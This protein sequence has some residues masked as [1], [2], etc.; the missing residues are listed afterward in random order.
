MRKFLYDVWRLLRFIALRFKQ[1]RCGQAAASLTFTTLL[2][3]VPMITIALTIFGAFPVFQDFSTEI[4]NYLLSN[5]MP[6]KA[7]AII[8]RYVEQF[9]ESA[10]RLKTVGIV[11]LAVTAMSMMMTI[12]KTFNVIW[13]VTR[14]RPLLKRWLVYAAVLTMAPLLIGAS[15]SLT[16]WLVGLSL[17]YAKH[18]PVFGVQALNLLPGLFTALA[19]ALL[20]KLVPNRHVPNEH[21]YIAALFSAV[22]FEGMNRVFG[23][24]ISHFP[25]YKMVYGAFASVPIFLMWIYL[26]W[27]IILLG[28][29]IAASLSHWR[30]QDVENQPP[31]VDMLQ[32]MQMLREL[33]RGMK[34]GHATTLPDMSR[35]LRVGY[36]TLEHILQRLEHAK[37][38][39]KAKGYGWTLSPA[40][41]NIQVTEL[42]QLFALDRTALNVQRD[43]ALKA[44]LA[45]AVESMEQNSEITLLELFTTYP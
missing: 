33:W 22:L 6:D 31:I 4:K 28:A 13:R 21:A 10:T 11:I 25:T 37:L 39:R 35:Q 20:F 24:Y 2:A 3:L 23:H 41:E 27:L 9:A 42:L 30:M 17:G 19:F 14:P 44:W 8:T 43:D 29:V 26:S 12:D 38:V 45:S 34:N 16:S 36:D 1:E 7:G 5:M 32:A 15:L 18:I 40:A